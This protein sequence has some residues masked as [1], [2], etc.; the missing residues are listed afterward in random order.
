MGIG[1]VLCYIVFRLRRFFVVVFFG[2]FV[3]LYFGRG[4]VS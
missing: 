4:S 2:F 3:V 1:L